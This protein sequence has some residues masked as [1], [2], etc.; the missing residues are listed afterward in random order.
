MDCRKGW[1][2]DGNGRSWSFEP[3]CYLPK[4]DRPFLAMKPRKP[5]LL[6]LESF[7]F[8]LNDPFE[9]PE[10][11]NETISVLKF[12]ISMKLEP[13]VDFPSYISSLKWYFHDFKTSKIHEIQSRGYYWY[14]QDGTHRGYIPDYNEKSKFWFHN[15]NLQNKI[16]YNLFI[17]NNLISYDFFLFNKSLF[18]FH[19]F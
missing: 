13:K 8:G 2:R 18:I 16:T 12:V 7:E 19:F 6:S 1:C 5:V 14:Y 11:F 17:I 10:Y 4:T 9:S 3:L 15:S